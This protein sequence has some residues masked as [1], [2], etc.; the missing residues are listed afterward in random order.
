MKKILIVLTEVKHTL[1]LHI[2]GAQLYYGKRCPSLSEQGLRG[3]EEQGT[4]NG[5]CRSKF[6]IAVRQAEVV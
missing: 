2:L 4:C 6:F 1:V 3:T 5:I